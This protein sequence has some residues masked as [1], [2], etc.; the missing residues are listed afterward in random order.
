MTSDMRSGM[1]GSETAA[2]PIAIPLTSSINWKQR[3]GC[4]LA[5][6]TNSPSRLEKEI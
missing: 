6:P 2:I 3:L 4:S 1:E 5:Q